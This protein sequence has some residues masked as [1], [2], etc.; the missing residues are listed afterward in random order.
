M[1]LPVGVALDKETLVF[2]EAGGT[3]TLLA[4]VMPGNALIKDL[5]WSSS[6]E[7]VATVDDK[8]VVTAVGAGEAVITV[9][10]VPPY[11]ATDACTVKVAVCPSRERVDG[12]GD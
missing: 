8:G 1:I 7:T 10:T 4:T 6:D 3:D 11:R 9:T 2:A 5:K 12:G